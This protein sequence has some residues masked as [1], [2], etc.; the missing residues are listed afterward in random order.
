MQ[1]SKMTEKKPFWETKK[2]FEMTNG[3]W[4]SLCDGCAKCCLNKL[5]DADTGYISYTNVACHQLD[6]E[7]CKCRNYS[8][9]ETYVPDC[10]KLTVSKLESLSW[11]P[12]TCAYRL[13]YEQKTL[14]PWHPL[15]SGDKESVE[16]SGISVKGRIISENNNIDLEEHI[17]DWP[18]E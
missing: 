14:Y 2:L 5:E 10:I 16:K 12:R 13:L 3:E 1:E 18:N 4:E 17:V 7:S 6:I 8:D 15:I 11:L 9:R